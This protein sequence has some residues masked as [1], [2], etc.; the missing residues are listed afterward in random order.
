M[1][2]IPALPDEIR[3]PCDDV[4]YPGV[5]AVARPIDLEDK[6]RW[7]DAF[8]N[9]DLTGGEAATA[10]VKQQLIRVDGLSVQDANGAV[11]PYDHGNALHWRS[12]PMAIRTRVF[13]SLFARST[14][15][16]EQE[17]NSDLPSG[18]G[19]TSGTENSPAAPAVND[20]ATS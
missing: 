4:G 20:V 15:T 14:L 5:V 3:V 17:K 2:V 1:Y 7:A 9:L 6:S 11:T 13:N 12:L 18:S 19:G 10:M 8:P 16:G